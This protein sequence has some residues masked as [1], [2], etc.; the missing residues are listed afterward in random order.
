MGQPPRTGAGTQTGPAGGPHARAKGRITACM[1]REI[2]RDDWQQY[3]EDFSRN[4]PDYIAKVEILSGELGAET[5]AEGTHLAA[6]TYDRKDDIVVIGL[7]GAADGIAEEVQHVIERP[8]KI[9]VDDE[10]GGE[11]AFEIEDAEGTQTV[12]RLDRAG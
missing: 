5:E 1:A 11:I 12:L 8:L 7:D 2:P 6:I 4:Q 3:F 9:A 10:S